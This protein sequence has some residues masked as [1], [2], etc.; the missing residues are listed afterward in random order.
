MIYSISVVSVGR[1]LNIYSSIKL[2][3]FDTFGYFQIVNVGNDCI[4]CVND[5]T[6]AFKVP[7]I[8]STK[9]AI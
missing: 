5:E 7:A 4:I 3:Y 1:N 6:K 9:P 8:L 2:D